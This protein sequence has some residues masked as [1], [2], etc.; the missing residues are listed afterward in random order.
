MMNLS[1]CVGRILLKLPSPLATVYITTGAKLKGFVAASWQF[2]RNYKRSGL[3]PVKRWQYY[4]TVF[5]N[6]HFALLFLF[7]HYKPQGQDLI[8]PAVKLRVPLKP[9]NILTNTATVNLSNT[10]LI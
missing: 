3:Q 5:F 7:A 9:R 1:R 6:R 4:S 10:A 8:N 2:V